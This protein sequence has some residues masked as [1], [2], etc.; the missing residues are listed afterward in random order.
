MKRKILVTGA[1][2]KLGSLVAEALLKKTEA[3][4]IV[5]MVRDRAK[6]RD[7]DAKG[8]EVRIANYNDKA[9]M[10][11][12]FNN[13]GKIYFVSGNDLEKRVEQHKNVVKAAEEAKVDHVI[14]TSFGPGNYSE[15]SPFYAVA[16][17]HLAAEESLKNS[18][19]AYTILKH[20]LY[21]EVIPLFAGENLLESKTIFLPAEDG[22]TAFMARKDMAFL[23]AEILTGSGHENKIYDVSGDKSYSFNEIASLISEVSGKEINY[24]SP[25]VEEFQA[26][27]KGYG[28]SAPAIAMTVMFAKGIAQGEFN[29]TAT[30]FKDLTG[31]DITSL[32]TFLKEVYGSK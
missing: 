1:T 6:A 15:N 3:S 2:G 26:T 24:I 18:G 14:Y 29:K 5:V 8:I 12:A 27:L 25:S 16:K 31:K 9:S 23:A 21:M 13:I 10:T 11:K 32:K 28:V 17:G 19:L 7:L 22:K 4:N 30:T 20:N